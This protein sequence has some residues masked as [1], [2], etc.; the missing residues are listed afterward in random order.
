MLRIRLLKA[1]HLFC[2][3]DVLDVEV[4]VA[5]LLI[6]RGIAEEYC[7]TNPRAEQEEQDRLR[8]QVDAYR[9]EID[10]LKI[11]LERRQVALAQTRGAYNNL[12]EMY[13]QVLS[14]KEENR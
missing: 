1:H 2:A 12:R 8:E 7:S 13:R 14:E 5:A 4:G 10:R 9:Q 6:E 11:E 3:G